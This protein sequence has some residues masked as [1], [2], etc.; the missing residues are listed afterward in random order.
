M[1]KQ[2]FASFFVLAAAVTAYSQAST[3]P[4]WVV[5]DSPDGLYSV[6]LPTKPTLKQQQAND[7]DGKPVEQFLASANEG[8]VTMMIGYFDYFAPQT[9]SF[10]NARDGMIRNI[11]GKLFSEET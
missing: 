9:F 1:R 7:K 5:Y 10:D 11:D 2:I 4:K 6:L 8:N 3:Q